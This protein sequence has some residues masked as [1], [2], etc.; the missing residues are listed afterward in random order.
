[1]TI[2]K[3]DDAAGYQVDVTLKGGERIRRQ[4]PDLREARKLEGRLEEAGQEWLPLDEAM[5]AYSAH[6][7]VR[8]KERT[9]SYAEVM[10][11]HLTRV[12]GPETNVATLT[13]ADLNRFVAA[14]TAEGAP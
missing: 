9:V 4:A 6:C 13:P 2:R 8:G 7:R 12:L 3:R 10:R 1:V 11:T 14:R 5:A